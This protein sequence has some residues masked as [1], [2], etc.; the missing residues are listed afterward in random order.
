MRLVKMG[1]M[2]TNLHDLHRSLTRSLP[3]A[4]SLDIRQHPSAVELAL[5]AEF[6][7]ALEEPIAGTY[8]YP[9]R[10]GVTAVPEDDDDVLPWLLAAL[11][12]AAAVA[13]LLTVLRSYLR[14][15]FNV[16]GAAALAHMGSNDNFILRDAAL[17]ASINA[18]ANSLTATGSDIS[19]TRTTANDLNA[20]ILAGREAGLTA[21]ELEQVLTDYIAARALVRAGAISFN[22]LVRLSRRGEATTYGRNGIEKLVYRMSRGASARPDECDEAEGH[23]Y[24]VSDSGLIPQHVNCACYWQAVLKGWKRPSRWWTGG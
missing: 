17:I 18:W 12:G 1:T 22:E 23:E 14:Q 4:G 19:L 13:G 5:E 15:S 24:A 3:L 9:L 16:G 8:R 6:A 20:Q 21:A 10:N 2:S 11:G 7:T